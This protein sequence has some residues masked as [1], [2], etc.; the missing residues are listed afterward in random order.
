M[1]LYL[2]RPTFVKCPHCSR[3]MLPHMVCTNCGY[4]RGREVI[5]V[6]KGISKKERK[7]KEKEI[8][9]KEEK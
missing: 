9:K 4:Y 5:D 7:Q 2:H 6:L 8:A 1:H 3:S